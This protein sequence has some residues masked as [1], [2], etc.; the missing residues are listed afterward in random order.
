MQRSLPKHVFRKNGWL[1][2]CKRGMPSVKLRHQFPDGKE[3]WP[4]MVSDAE[5]IIA[6]A[7]EVQIIG[8]DE[9]AAFWKAME[10]GARS[11]ASKYGRDF[12]LPPGWMYR[13]F[14][15]QNGLCAI[16]GLNM[17]RD[18]DKHAPFAP[19]IDRINPKKGYVEGNCQL[20]CY[21]VNCAKNQFSMDEL[22]TVSRAIVAIQGRNKNGT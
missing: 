17:Y 5:F 18:R 13:Q 9:G 19:S 21:I 1:Y 12:T 7:K 2:F 8:D 22:L 3:D 14:V 11:R 20:V 6:A 15:K 16:S 10:K 4:T